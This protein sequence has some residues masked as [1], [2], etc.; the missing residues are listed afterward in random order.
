VH[1]VDSSIF[2]PIILPVL[3]WFSIIS[4]ALHHLRSHRNGRPSRANHL[5]GDLLCQL[6]EIPKA[7]KAR[8]SALVSVLIC[9]CLYGAFGVADN[10]VLTGAASPM[11]LVTVLL[12]WF[13]TQMFP[14]ASTAK[15]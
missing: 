1:A 5:C 6:V 10:G 13:E 4:F 9:L 7:S 14:L 12:P 11:N 2:R 3:R 15:A 8:P